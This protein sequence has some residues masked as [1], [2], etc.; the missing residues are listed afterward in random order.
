MADVYNVTEFYISGRTRPFFRRSGIF[1]TPRVGESL[2]VA[3]VTGDVVT[4]TW[5][6]DYYEEAHEQWRCNIY[7]QPHSSLAGEAE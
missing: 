7:V 1:N 4:V 5:N 3:G 2:N 6:L